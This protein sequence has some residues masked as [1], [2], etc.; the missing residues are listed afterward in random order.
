MDPI[1]WIYY[2]LDIYI[3]ISLSIYGSYIPTIRALNQIY[4]L[5]PP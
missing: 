4:F 3:S 2:F 1:W 5:N